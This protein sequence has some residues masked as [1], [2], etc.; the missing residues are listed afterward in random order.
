MRKP[1]LHLRITAHLAWFLIHAMGLAKSRSPWIRKALFFCHIQRRDLVVTAF[2]WKVKINTGYRCNL[3]CPLCATGL[4]E[5]P[6]KPDLS[7]EMF[8]LLLDKLEPVE[9]VYLFGWGEPF[10]NKDIFEMIRLAK[11]RG[12]RVS[13]DSNLSLVSDEKMRSIVE[14]GIDVLSVSLDGVSQEVYE[15]YRIG[16]DYELVV[17]NIRR[18][19][20]IKREL[21]KQTPEVQ[22]QYIVNRRNEK[23][24]D[25]ASRAAKELGVKIKFMPIGLY[26]DNFNPPDSQAA[27]A[28][29]PL[30]HASLLKGQNSM[31][32][33]INPAG[34][35]YLLYYFPLI[36][37]DG[38]VFFCCPCAV[39]NKKNSRVDDRFVTTAGNLKDAEFM[40]IFN[41]DIYRHAR[42]LF[43]PQKTK[44]LDKPMPCDVCRMYR[45]I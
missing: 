35:C 11:S 22:W 15:Q 30:K 9:E 40:T 16:G 18:I 4:R 1:K 14:S 43:S 42:S 23:D 29:L 33:P 37:V 12:K 28:W 24:L 3:K 13:I 5:S 27:E 44:A 10:I 7:I 32:T 36:D 39:A 2:P 45:A 20:E 17:K 38:D 31:Q 34:Y 41:N 8:R 6:P 25:R 19:Q 26:L 21:K